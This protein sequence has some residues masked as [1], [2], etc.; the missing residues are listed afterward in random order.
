MAITLFDLTV[1]TYTQVLESAIG[2]LEKS[3]AHFIE[4]GIDL[5]EIV[6]STL[7]ED[8]QNFYFQVV[9]ANH[10][11]TKTIE[12]LTSG[13]FGPPAHAFGHQPQ[14]G[15]YDALI[16]MT[17]DSVEMMKAQDVDAI[18]ALAEKTITFKMGASELPF[19]TENF[20]LSFSLPNFYFHATTAYDILRM[21]GVKIGKMDFL[22]NM[23]MGH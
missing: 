7:C 18:N 4:N 10:H 16:A 17:K 21:K 13:E 20:V 14:E 19:T 11:S 9:S 8:M 2:F 6:G 15:D 12:A 22:G 3:K 5:N 1:G 23:R